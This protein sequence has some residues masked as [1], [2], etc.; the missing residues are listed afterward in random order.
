MSVL[1]DLRLVLY[2]VVCA[3]CVFVE[4]DAAKLG[5]TGSSCNFVWIIGN[6]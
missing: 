3:Q 4:L 5:E 2:I 6:S 1:T